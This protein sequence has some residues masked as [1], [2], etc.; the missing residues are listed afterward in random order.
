MAT[1]YIAIQSGVTEVDGEA[2]VF[3]KGKTLVEEGHPMLD[4][5][6]DY[7]VPTNNEVHYEHHEPVA[8]KPA[9]RRTA[10]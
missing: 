8:K 1:T 4:N 5:V 9:G 2:L 3:V 7:F 10:S 6:P